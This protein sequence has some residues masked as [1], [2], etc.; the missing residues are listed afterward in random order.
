MADIPD[1]EIETSPLGGIVTRDG[2]MVQVHIYR[3]AGSDDEWTLEV[4]DHE[5]G[6]TTWTDTFANDEDAFKAFEQAVA[7]DGIRSFV[8]QQVEH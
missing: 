8:K 3:F 7:K 6:H 1:Q 5:G 4:V 2:V